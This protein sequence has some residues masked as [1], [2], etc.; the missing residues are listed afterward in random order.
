MRLL[1]EVSELRAH[2]CDCEH[3]ENEVSSH[4][5]REKVFYDPTGMT[6]YFNIGSASQVVLSQKASIGHS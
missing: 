6:D 1:S 2:K 5:V 3:L 4:H